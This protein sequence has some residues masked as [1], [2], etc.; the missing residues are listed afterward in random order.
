MIPRQIHQIWI[1]PKPLPVREKGW[2]EQ[3]QRMNHDWSYKLHGNELLDRY[4]ADPYIKHLLAVESELAF[5]SDRLRMLLLRDEGGLYVDVDA[6][7][8]RPWSSLKF[9]DRPEVTF[10]YGIR[11]P[12]RPGVA[13]NRGLAIVDNSVLASAKNSRM[14]GRIL[15]EW[16]PKEIKVNGHRIGRQ[17]MRWTDVDC[18]ALN[19]RYFYDMIPGPDAIAAHDGHNLGS[20]VQNPMKTPVALAGETLKL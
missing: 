8:L 5:V 9:W 20:W 16:T 15:E 6:Q 13:L 7:P 1:G 11:N 10:M 12:D 19:Y 17:I 14:A 3:T 4:A 18:V 2:C